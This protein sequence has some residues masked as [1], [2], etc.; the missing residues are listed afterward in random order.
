MHI[1]TGYTPLY[2]FYP[3]YLD[4]EKESNSSRSPNSFSTSN[5]FQKLSHS[6]NT[7]YLIQPSGKKCWILHSCTEFL[8]YGPRVAVWFHFRTVHGSYKS[9][10]LATTLLR[11][12][13]FEAGMSI[14]GSKNVIWMHHQME[15]KHRQHKFIYQ[16]VKRMCTVLKAGSYCCPPI[17]L[18]WADLGIYGLWFFFACI[19]QWDANENIL[20][21]EFVMKVKLY[22]ICVC[23]CTDRN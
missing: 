21:Y 14:R 9:K 4:S 15:S 23:I 6:C 2:L 18:Q 1:H 12:R 5:N 3:R 11:Y 22:Q 16:V 20:K 13:F 19:N 10:Y 17:T 8:M 7:M